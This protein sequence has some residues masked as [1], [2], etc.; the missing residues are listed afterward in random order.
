MS[1]KQ[2]Q[3][4]KRTPLGGPRATGKVIEWKGTHGWIQSTKPVD[5]PLA[6]KHKGRVYLAQE[7]VKEELSGV[8]A[9]VS[10]ALYTDASGLGASDC[11]KAAF[12]ETGITKSGAVAAYRQGVTAPQATTSLKAAAAA[13][14]MSS[15]KTASPRAAASAKAASAPAKTST[16]GGLK[17]SSAVAAYRANSESFGLGAKSQGRGKAKNAA[18]QAVAQ[19]VQKKPRTDGG[20]TAGGQLARTLVSDEPVF[21][22]VT[23]WKGTF[24][25][26]K[27]HEDIDHPKYNRKTRRGY[28]YFG[29]EDVEAELEGVGAAVSFMVYEDEKGLG[30]MNL[31]PA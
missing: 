2:A 30:A 9:S 23:D 5:H 1:P 29:Q 22:T 6:A 25:W 19:P 13:K 24:G 15:Q 16:P 18:T 3:N 28:L 20:N 21:G 4:G 8:G 31:S 17:K 12:K 26:V 14:V 11:K 10:F 7:D 27:P